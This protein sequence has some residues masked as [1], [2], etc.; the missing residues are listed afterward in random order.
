MVVVKI[1][2]IKVLFRRTAGLKLNDGCYDKNGL[3]IS[4]TRSWPMAAS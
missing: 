1:E 2:E 3:E 4:L